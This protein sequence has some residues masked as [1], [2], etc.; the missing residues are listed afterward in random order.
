MGRYLNQNSKGGLPAVGKYEALI[1]DGGIPDDGKVFKENLVC[2]VENG[3]FDAA[4]YAYS[5]REFEAMSYPDGRRKKWLVYPLA[6]Q[7]SSK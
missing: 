1:A 7:L 2:V 4:G 5:E 6:D 3:P